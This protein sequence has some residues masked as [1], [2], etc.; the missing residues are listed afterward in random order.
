MKVEISQCLLAIETN[1]LICMKVK[2]KKV[3]KKVKV[4][5]PQAIF[6]RYRDDPSQPLMKTSGSPLPQPSLSF[7]CI[8]QLKTQII[9]LVQSFSGKSKRVEVK[10]K[11]NLIGEEE[12]ELIFEVQ[13]KNIF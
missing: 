5:T 4:K 7:I 12:K 1:P 9:C 13:N 2:I 3:T 6:T 10:Q 11:I 8:F